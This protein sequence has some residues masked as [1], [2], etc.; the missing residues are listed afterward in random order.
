MA[1][2]NFGDS[3]ILCRFY[4]FV[5]FGQNSNSEGKLKVSTSLHEDS[6]ISMGPR[7]FNVSTSEI[8]P[9]NIT[10]SPE[11]ISQVGIEKI[12]FAMAVTLISG[13]TQL[14]MG[15]LNMGIIVRLMSD[16]LVSGFS[17]G[18]AIY[19]IS[20]QLKYI[21]GLTVQRY[22][23][24][25]SVPMVIFSTVVSYYL[26][27][28]EKNNFVVIGD[29]P[30]GLP[31]PVLPD[32]SYAADYISQSI[33]IGL[34]AFAQSISVAVIIARKEGYDIN[35]NKELIAYGAV[36]IICPIFNCFTAAGA[37]SRTT[38]QFSSG[39]KSQIASLFGSFF[40][41]LMILAAGPLLR[42]LP[43]CVLSAIIL[44]S[45]KS[46]LKEICTLKRLWRVS[47]CDCFIWIGTFLAIILTT[48]ELGLIIGIGIG[49]ATVLIRTQMVRPIK[50]GTIERTEIFR[51]RTKYQ[52]TTPQTP[53][54]ILSY[55]SPL[56]YA[57]VE[58]F[59]TKVKEK[60][61]EFNKL[62][63]NKSADNNISTN[64]TCKELEQY[65]VI[66][67]CSAISFIDA[68]GA[69]AFKQLFLDA[70]QE[71]VSCL[72]SCVNDSVLSVLKASDVFET[73][74]NSLYV[75]TY[76]ALMAIELQDED[77]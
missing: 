56:Y 16:S 54:I 33:I 41:L 4:C 63:K 17:C 55:P 34:V 44:V 2:R 15:I 59:Q 30:S 27:L 25:L 60:F 48:I 9:E 36:N 52:V 26:K 65:Y 14:L 70:K 43:N 73:L 61:A 37:L 75:T 8:F 29:I 11:K 20:S 18:V 21:L 45:L 46:M 12:K 58:V 6:V 50:L 13:I 23:G 66:I 10:I 42:P 39:G 74:Q 19:I 1:E 47:P 22:T 71:S 72:F 38:V 35:A 3:Q 67:D 68:M 62:S 24:V 28:H 49:A 69:K 57:N 7:L 31:M 77:V 51:D 76:D 53:V 64:S 40:V 5:F 32:I